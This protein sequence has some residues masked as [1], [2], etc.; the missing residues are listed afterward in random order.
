MLANTV[1][2]P[3]ESLVAMSDSERKHEKK[4]EKQ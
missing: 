4:G 1:A 3:F 2:S